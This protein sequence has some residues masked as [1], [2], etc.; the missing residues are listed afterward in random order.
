MANLTQTA[1]SVRVRGADVA[2]EV[3][4]AGE[5]ITAGMAC[6]ARDGKWYKADANAADPNTAALAGGGG[7]IA[8]ALTDAAGVD[9]SLLVARSGPID[10]GATLAVGMVYI[11]STT[12]GAIAPVADFAGYTAAYCTPLGMATAANTL[13]LDPKFTGA[14]NLA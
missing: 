3:V 11:L 1:A 9:E 10:L 2:T 13:R 8:V 4:T 14:N 5:A 12:P 6:V 7:Q